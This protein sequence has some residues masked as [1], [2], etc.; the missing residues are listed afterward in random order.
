MISSSRSFD[1]VITDIYTPACACRPEIN[2]KKRR[3]L[4]PFCRR[5]ENRLFGTIDF[6]VEYHGK[7]FYLISLRLLRAPKLG[8]T[9]DGR[10]LGT[11]HCRDLFPLFTTLGYYA[12]GV[13]QTLDVENSSHT[14]STQKFWRSTYRYLG[15]RC[16]PDTILFLSFF[17]SYDSHGTSISSSQRDG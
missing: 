5:L 11:A 12:N 15:T 2:N 7:A 4:R 16:Q 10:A 8:R 17:F 9:D 1:L 3:F 13:A 6:A 14:K